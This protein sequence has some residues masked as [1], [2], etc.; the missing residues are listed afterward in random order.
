MSTGFIQPVT[1]I[2]AIQRNSPTWDYP[3]TCSAL[4]QR[5]TGAETRGHTFLLETDT[6]SKLCWSGGDVLLAELCVWGWMHTEVHKAGTKHRGFHPLRIQNSHWQQW[7]VRML[8]HGVQLG[9]RSNTAA[10]KEHVFVKTA[11]KGRGYQ[12]LCHAAHH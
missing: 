6:G 9:K 10:G 12:S 11:C 3:L 8:N 7:W 1:W 5:L 4:M 2:G